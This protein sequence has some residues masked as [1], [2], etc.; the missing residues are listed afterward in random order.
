MTN[1]QKVN[2]LQK[3]FF[4][5][6]P[7]ADLSD[8]PATTYPQEAPCENKI[9]LRQIHDVINRLAPNKAPGPVEIA[10]ILSEY[11]VLLSTK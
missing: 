2:V 9:T 7:K 8:I 1:E 11:K 3:T 6:P 5:K 4:P 10:N